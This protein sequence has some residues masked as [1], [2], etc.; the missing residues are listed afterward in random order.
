MMNPMSAYCMTPVCKKRSKFFFK[1]L[2]FSDFPNVFSVCPAVKI[3]EKTIKAKNGIVSLIRNTSGKYILDA[4]LE[5]LFKKYAPFPPATRLKTI[6]T[7]RR[8]S[9]NGR[10][11]GDELMLLS[12]LFVAW[13]R[14]FGSESGNEKLICL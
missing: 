4:L 3:R 5:T 8:Y 13:L 12:T 11:S 14:G 10:S 1:V 7:P 6:V 9:A 2:F